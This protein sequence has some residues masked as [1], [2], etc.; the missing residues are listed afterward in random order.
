MKWEYK[1][2]EIDAVEIERRTP[3]NKLNKLGQEGWELV[4]AFQVTTP[5]KETAFATYTFKRLCK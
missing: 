5:R 4:A 3:Q 2:L 1:T